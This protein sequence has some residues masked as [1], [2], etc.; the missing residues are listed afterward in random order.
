[1]RYGIQA[2]LLES[3]W[4]TVLKYG[5]VRCKIFMYAE[6]W[7]PE[8][9]DRDGWGKNR[10]CD[11]M[12]ANVFYQRSFRAQSLSC[13][14]LSPPVFAWSLVRLITKYAASRTYMKL[15]APGHPAL[16]GQASIDLS[17]DRGG[18]LFGAQSEGATVG[19][20]EP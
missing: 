18:S 20:N 5:H 11:G 15:C 6:A 13:C 14:T 1:M 3:R 10:K 7:R 9:D 19:G 17:T 8:T 12:D 4:L 2:Y 16:H